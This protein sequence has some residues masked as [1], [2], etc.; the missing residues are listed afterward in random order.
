MF[1]LLSFALGCGGEEQSPPDPLDQVMRAI[2]LGGT[3]TLTGGGLGQPTMGGDRLAGSASGGDG[4]GRTAGGGDGLGRTAGG[5][6]GIG[7]PP[8][9]DGSAGVTR[10][11]ACEALCGLARQCGSVIGQGDCVSECAAAFDQFGLDPN[12]AIQCAS[13][14]CEVLEECLEDAIRGSQGR[15]PPSASS[16][17]DPPNT[18]SPGQPARVPSE[19]TSEIDR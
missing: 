9:S 10:R 4:L 11:S 1:T 8:G 2:G 19:S 15:P 3:G 6:D 16:P 12:V 7:A 18:S 14:A 13:V 17:V 5:G